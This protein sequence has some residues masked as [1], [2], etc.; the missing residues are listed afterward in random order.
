[1]LD[2]VL[3]ALREIYTRRGWADII[4]LLVI[5]IGVYASM[6]F[7]R[8]T[9]GARILRG[10]T[11]LLVGGTLVVFL[12][13]NLLELERIKVLYPT[14]VGALFLIALVAF[15]PELRRALIRLGAAS[16]FV[17]TKKEVDRLIEEVV[18]AA[19]YLAKNKIGAIMAFERSTEFGALVES[20]C[21]LDAEVSEELLT[22]IFWPGSSLHDMGVVISQ[23]RVAAAAVQ[24]P[25]AEST[26][27][28]DPSFGSRHRAAL[29]I[30]QESDAIVLIIS[31]ETG[32]I[33][34][35]EHGTMRRFLTPDSLR[36]LL[37]EKLGRQTP[38]P[39]DS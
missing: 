27:D 38:E 19:T 17:G 10:F 6:R 26:D 14:F 24:F 32:N 15:Q 5:G 36:Q 12:A 2:Q 39:E 33:T 11:L 22:T 37:K 30:S 23:G 8:G 7:L 25:L 13:A 31:E 29:G 3:D 20:G 18:K 4:E 28:L 34:I 16:W 35:V 21:T 9:R 1:M